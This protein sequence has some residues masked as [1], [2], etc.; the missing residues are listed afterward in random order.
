MILLRP[1][2]CLGRSESSLSAKLKSLDLSHSSSNEDE[3]GAMNYTWAPFDEIR[4]QLFS[5][6]SLQGLTFSLPNKGV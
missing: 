5:Q 6:G 3:W 4:G 1:G 2:G